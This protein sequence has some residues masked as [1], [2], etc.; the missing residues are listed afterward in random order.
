[1]K[2]LIKDHSLPTHCFLL[3]LAIVWYAASYPHGEE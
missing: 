2:V 3:L 1:M